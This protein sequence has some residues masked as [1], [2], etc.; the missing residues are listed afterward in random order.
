[1]N[2]EEASKVISDAT[3]KIVPGTDCGEDELALIG[4]LLGALYALQRAV[5]L[6]FVDRTGDALPHD[7]AIELSR[8]ASQINKTEPIQENQW[9]AGFY[10][11]SAIHRLAALNE[12]LTKYIFGCRV[13]VCTEL[14]KENNQFKHEIYGLISGRKVGIKQAVSAA[15]KLSNAVSRILKAT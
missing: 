6:E 9:L 11:N 5:S 1:M 2:F 13:D 14:R 12:R 3:K 15:S 7:Y 8:V 4:T 10:L